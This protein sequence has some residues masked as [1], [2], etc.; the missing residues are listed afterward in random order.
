MPTKKKERSGKSKADSIMT[1]LSPSQKLDL[2][3]RSVSRSPKR[4][5]AMAVLTRERGGRQ[6]R[7]SAFLP[8][9]TRTADC[10]ISREKEEKRRARIAAQLLRSMVVAG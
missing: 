7:R 6:K 8:A 4:K 10:G 3:K 9:S 5:V 1:A 2:L